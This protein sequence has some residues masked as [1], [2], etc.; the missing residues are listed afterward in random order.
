LKSACTAGLSTGEVVHTEK[1]SY[2]PRLAVSNF[3]EAR[4][5]QFGLTVSYASPRVY[6]DGYDIRVADFSAN[7]GYLFY[8]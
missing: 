4:W 5:N 2:E 6:G 3:L 8:F 7:L 1:R